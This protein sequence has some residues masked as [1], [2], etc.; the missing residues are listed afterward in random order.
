[1]H[2]IFAVATKNSWINLDTRTPKAQKQ[3]GIMSPSRVEFKD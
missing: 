1:M 2:T 3:S